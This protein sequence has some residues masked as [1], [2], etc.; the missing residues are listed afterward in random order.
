MVTLN[1]V[2]AARN[3]ILTG[4]RLTP[5]PHSESLS[6]LT[7]SR[8]YLK[9]ENLQVTGS[10]KDRGALNKISTLTEDER[11][12]GVIAASAGNH[13]QAVSYF[14]TKLGIRAQICMP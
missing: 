10:F 8:L 5:C 2:R 3:R 14:T 6:D 4:I 13:A 12:C 9:M 7:G 11:R 1:S